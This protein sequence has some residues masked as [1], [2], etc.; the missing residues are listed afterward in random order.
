[1]KTVKNSGFSLGEVLIAIF[2]IGLL[3]MSVFFVL[4]Y[5]K[6]SSADAKRVAD[7]KKIDQALVL[8]YDQYGRYPLRLEELV[9][10]GFLGFVPIPPIG[11]GQN[12]YIYVPLMENQTCSGYHLGASLQTKSSALNN[13]SDA[14]PGQPCPGAE[15]VDFDGTA[16]FCEPGVS[17]E[18]V[19]NDSCF[20]IRR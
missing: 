4:D 9:R 18:G 15:T 17:G 8:Y 6:M 14:Y 19:S 10:A 13:D 5:I 16:L 11:A 1:M 12:R 3:A 7:L 20:D 2:I